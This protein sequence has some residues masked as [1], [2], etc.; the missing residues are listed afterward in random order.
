MW[1]IIQCKAIQK[2]RGTGMVF[3][4][5]V[6]I[7]KNLFKSILGMLTIYINKASGNNSLVLWYGYNLKT[8]HYMKHIVL[9]N[10]M[11][12][13]NEILKVTVCN[14]DVTDMLETVQNVEY[15]QCKQLKLT[16][17]IGFSNGGGK[18]E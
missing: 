13:N 14:K 17:Q 12:Y 3:K 8:K 16:K 10:L 1:N 6:F 4:V 11:M 15:K 18:I 9:Y 5:D 7:E 2:K